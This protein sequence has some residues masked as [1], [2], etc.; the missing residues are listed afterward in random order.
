M[1]ENL[2]VSNQMQSLIFLVSIWWKL[3][4]SAHFIHLIDYIEWSIV[5][6]M[7]TDLFYFI[8]LQLISFFLSN[9]QF[10]SLTTAN[11]NNFFFCS[12]CCVS[13]PPHSLP[14][15]FPVVFVCNFLLYNVQVHVSLHREKE[16]GG[17]RCVCVCV[18][19]AHYTT[20]IKVYLLNIQCHCQ[21]VQRH[22]MFLYKCIYLLS[23]QLWSIIFRCSLHIHYIRSKPIKKVAYIIYIQLGFFLS[24]LVAFNTTIFYVPCSL[25]ALAKKRGTLNTTKKK[26]KK[27]RKKSLNDKC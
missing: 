2:S 22:Y 19:A 1:E 25:I 12:A 4:R 11:F 21:P 3:M 7:H 6:H 8:A 14:L 23:W 20:R 5:W 17:V 26:V 13:A 16:S 15:S 18:R 24:L 27:K 10:L 9:F